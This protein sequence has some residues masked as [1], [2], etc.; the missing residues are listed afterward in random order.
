M[1]ESAG[2]HIPALAVVFPPQ[3]IQAL[4]QLSGH[5]SNARLQKLQPQPHVRA[6]ARHKPTFYSPRRENMVRWLLARITLAGVSRPRFTGS[7]PEF[8]VFNLWNKT[9]TK[10]AG[11]TE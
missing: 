7:W 10:T 11:K 4:S 8:G 2:N 1:S 6:F 3:N 5:A 9:G